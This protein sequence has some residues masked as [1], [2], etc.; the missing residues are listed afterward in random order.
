MHRW[1]V[2]REQGWKLRNNFADPMEK[3]DKAFILTQAGGPMQKQNYLSFRKEGFSRL[4]SIMYYMYC[5][6]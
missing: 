5:V 1:V 6:K 3:C 2:R 4:P